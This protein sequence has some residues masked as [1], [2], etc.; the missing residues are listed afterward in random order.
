MNNIE[1]ILKFKTIRTPFSTI[2]N[3]VIGVHEGKISF[4]GKEEKLGEYH[5]ETVDFSDKIAAP[6]YIDIHI[7]GANKADT[8]DANLKS[9]DTISSFIATKGVTGFYPTTMTAPLEDIYKAIDA[10]KKAADGKVHGARIL[11]IHLEGPYFSKEKAGAQEA[12]YL[13]IPK[14]DE[15]RDLLNFGEGIIKRVSIAPEIPGGLEAIKFLREN[16]VVVALGHTNATFDIAMEGINLGAT[17]G[18]H[19]YNGM[20]NFHHREPGVLGAVLTSNNVFA[21]MIV[22][23]IHLHPAAVDLVVRCKGFD[24]TILITD[25]IMATGL[26]DGEYILG[27]AKI[28][29]KNGI[30]RRESGVLAGST[31]TLDKA[32][33]NIIRFLDIPVNRAIQMASY[34]PAR[35]LHIEDKKGSL[36]IGKDA[37]IVVLNEDLTVYATIIGGDI[38]YTAES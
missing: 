22:D 16:N 18:N 12:D 8:M 7:H 32:V 17:I 3:G 26:A 30:S 24:H 9:L 2:P 10:V 13:R 25:S 5:G 23:G 6:G 29:V 31:L 14:I 35:A 34:N 36:E 11:G 27:K 28:I 15:L 20:R 37:D 4:I 33:R 19:T 21:E 38:V 1:K